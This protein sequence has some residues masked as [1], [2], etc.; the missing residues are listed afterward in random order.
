MTESATLADVVAVVHG[1]YDPSTAEP[2]D[3]VGLVCGDP[4]QRVRR[5][6]VAVDP[7][8]ATVTEAL[9]EA[10]VDLLLTHHPLLLRPVSSM[11]A[12]T[13]A[14]RL[15]HR[16]VVLGVVDTAPLVPSAAGADVGLG[17]IGELEREVTLEQFAAVVAESL[18]R[19]AHGVRVQGDA[20]RRVRRVAVIGGSG[21]D[22]LAAATDAG[23]D[24][25][26]TSDLKHHLALDHR[27]AGGP[28]VIDVAH[29]ASEFP[30]VRAYAQTL[31]RDLR[32]AGFDVDVQWSAIVTDPWS[33]HLA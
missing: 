26:V 32:D 1:R 2:W 11:A 28:A 18:P 33:F 16:L 22:A 12:T 24:V 14:G 10:R 4:A 30:W 29:F 20:A 17:R 23:A 7:V 9:T 15:L 3:A 6:L 5:V 8:E 19:T 31:H 13:P 27:E 21:G 25:V